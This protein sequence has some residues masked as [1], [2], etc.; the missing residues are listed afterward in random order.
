MMQKFDEMA[1]IKYYEKV[2]AIGELILGALSAHGI[3][4][5]STQA[6]LSLCNN[7]HYGNPMVP[8][9]VFNGGVALGFLHNEP[10]RFFTPLGEKFFTL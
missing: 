1:L 6:D 5:F 8:A 2:F 9:V 4:V 10:R 3:E 7:N